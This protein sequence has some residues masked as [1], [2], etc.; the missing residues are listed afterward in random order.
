[1]KRYAVSP[2]NSRRGHRKTNP[3]RP[4]NGA[5][6][7]HSR[8]QTTALGQGGTVLREAEFGSWYGIYLS[9]RPESSRS[10]LATGILRGTLLSIATCFGGTDWDK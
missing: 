6:L 8:R 5:G 1:M 10:S 2:K 4:V 7:R 9:N 3:N